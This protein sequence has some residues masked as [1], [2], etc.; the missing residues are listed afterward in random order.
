MVAVAYRR[1]ALPIMWTWRKGTRGH[2]PASAQI[3]LFHAVRLLVPPGATV[4][5]CGDSEFGNGKLMK[6]F[7]KWEWKYVLRQK[8][9]HL[10]L[11]SDSQEWQR[12]DTLVTVS[13]QRC[14]LENVQLT[15]T[16]HHPCHF[17]AIWQ[18]GYKEPWLLAT[19]LKTAQQA[20]LFYSR[21]M[22]I[23][24]LFG[25]CKSNGFDIEVTRLQTLF[26]LNRLM[27]A[28]ALL[29]VWLLAFGSQIVKN[30]Q[31][32]LVDRSDRRALSLF[33]IGWDSI[34][35]RLA[36]EDDLSIRLL[37]YF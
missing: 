21:R 8:G 18:K 2:S 13:G 5:V 31:R 11:A 22:W 29:V 17:L 10:L 12:C 24:A 9:S 27:F 25:D 26:P 32:S 3:G 1:R 37:P 34:E 16:H 33:R 28:I 30:G 6:Q 36:N 4:I 14:W 20:R 35:R 19:N 7:D 23:E 15:Q